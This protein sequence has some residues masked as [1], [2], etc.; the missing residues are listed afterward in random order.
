MPAD[1][2]HWLTFLWVA[3]LGALAGTVLGI[4]VS[5]LPGSATSVST[6][7][8]AFAV[9][10]QFFS[11]VFF[12]FLELPGW[13]QQLAALFPL[14]WLT[15]GMRSAF[16]PDGASAF[17][18]AGGWEHGRIALVLAAWVIIG[19]MVCVRTFRWRRA[20]G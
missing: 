9:V 4:A 8:S 3:A 18:V 6:S 7:I 5:A 1:L 15:Q 16:L 12:G 13:M 10:L 17:E 11:G 19:V 20:D 2:A 14:K